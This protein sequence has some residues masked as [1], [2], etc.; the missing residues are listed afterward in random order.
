MKISDV[1]SDPGYESFWSRRTFHGEPHGHGSPADTQTPVGA[2]AGRT[3]WS[4]GA[5][6]VCQSVQTKT[7]QAGIHSGRKQ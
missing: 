2:D 3:Q 1:S 5:G 7:H 4:G 6:A